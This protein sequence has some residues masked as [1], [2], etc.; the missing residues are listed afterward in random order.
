MKKGL[1]LVLLGVLMTGCATQPKKPEPKAKVVKKKKSPSQIRREKIYSCVV[2]LL[3]RDVNAEIAECV[4]TN[5][6][7]KRRV[8]CK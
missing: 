2:K 4:C 1:L 6:Y 7:S 8:S 3:E 5:I